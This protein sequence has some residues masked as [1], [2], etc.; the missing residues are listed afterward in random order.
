[1]SVHYR[2]AIVSIGLLFFVFGF[3]TWLCSILIPYL[4]L[5]CEL[6]NFQAQLVSFA[7]YISYFVMAIP[8]GKV[9]KKPGL[10]TGSLWVC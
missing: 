8:A 7:F 10:K 1:M 2:K 3:I 4:Q 5:A 9:L 6:N